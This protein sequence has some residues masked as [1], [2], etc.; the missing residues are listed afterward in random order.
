MSCID[1][2]P[3]NTYAGC[4]FYLNERTGRLATPSTEYDQRLDVEMVFEQDRFAHVRFEARIGADQRPPSG[5]P[6][7][8]AA[9]EQSLTGTSGGQRF[10]VGCWHQLAVNASGNGLNVNG[11]YACTLVIE[12]RSLGAT[13]MEYAAPPPDRPDTPLD[14]ARLDRLV[15]TLSAIEASFV[16]VRNPG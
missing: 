4:S 14:R 15:A 3:A 5:P 12:N 1:P 10:A 8:Q 7:E 11:P 16:P 2:S 9:V 13:V 6:L